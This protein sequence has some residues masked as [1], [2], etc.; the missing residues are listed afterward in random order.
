MSNLVDYGL[1]LL[2]LYEETQGVVSQSRTVKFSGK[3]PFVPSLT[4]IPSDQPS[5]CGNSKFDKQTFN[6]D[7]QNTKKDLEMFNKLMLD[8]TFTESR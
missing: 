1:I 8:K 6:K 4:L 2:P 7:H 5:S 3:T